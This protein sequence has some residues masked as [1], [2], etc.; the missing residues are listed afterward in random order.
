MIARAHALKYLI[1]G[2][3]V[4]LMNRLGVIFYQAGFVKNE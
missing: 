1:G 3:G 2:N 4:N